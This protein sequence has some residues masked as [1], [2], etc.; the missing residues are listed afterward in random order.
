MEETEDESP[1]SQDCLA[2]DKTCR[3]ASRRDF[4]CGCPPYCHAC[5][6]AYI[7]S[8]L[9]NKPFTRPTCPGICGIMHPFPDAWPRQLLRSKETIQYFDLVAEADEAESGAALYCHVRACGR[10]IP[11]RNRQKRGVGLGVC[12]C[13]ERT[14]AGCHD[15]V[16]EGETCDEM[17]ARWEAEGVLKEELERKSRR[18]M[19]QLSCKQCPKCKIVIEKIDGCDAIRCESCGH[20]FCW[21]K[22]P[23]IGDTE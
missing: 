13:G 16:H 22:T 21:S 7:R 20:I 8:C 6:A 3:K 1:N 15:K 17:R 10:Y 11:V 12:N 18:T 23:M 19:E 2:C 14:C 5:A 9:S 4:P